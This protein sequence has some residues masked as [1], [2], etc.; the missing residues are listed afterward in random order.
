MNEPFARN[1]QKEPV[2]GIT[3]ISITGYKSLESECSIEVRPLTILAGANSSG[4]SSVIQPLLLLKQ[5]LEATY[6]PGALKLDGPNVKFT[7]ASQFFSRI[8]GKKEGDRF[9]IKL[10]LDGGLSLTNTYGRSSDGVLEIL[11]TTVKENEVPVTFTP[12]MN[13][14]E[15]LNLL[16]G[17]YGALGRNETVQILQKYLGDSSEELECNIERDRCF[18][19]LEC[20]SRPIL[21]IERNLSFSKRIFYDNSSSI[22]FFDDAIRRLIHVPGFRGNPERNYKI[23]GIGSTFP[24]T[25]ENYVAS[26]I[27]YWQKTEDERLIELGQAM[28]TLGLTS[29]VVAQKLNDIEIELLV[30]NLPGKGEKNHLI[31]IAD[32]GFGLSQILPVIVALIV[33]EPGQLVYLEQPEIH[34]HPRAREALAD[35]LVN[36]ANRGVRL[37]VETHSEFLLL[38]VQSLVAEGKL[39]PEK[40]KLH[41]LTKKEDETT[42]IS[43]GD[44]DKAGAYGDWPEDFGKLSLSLENRYLNAAEAHLFNT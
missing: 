18:L 37:V 42:K 32:V 17:Y 14:E 7:S 36:A 27:N 20:I 40:V 4:K 24:G 31:S 3:N 43:S 13:R 22:I 8:Q 39:S 38:A 2:R 30:S 34:L 16:L 9:S 6:D 44:L 1:N 25:F 5:T 41:W 28:A 11:E 35:L 33:A 15:I 12:T 29:K 19:N 21:E 23:T 26:I 10:T